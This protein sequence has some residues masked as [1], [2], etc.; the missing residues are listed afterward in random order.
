MSGLYFPPSYHT[1][2]FYVRYILPTQLPN[3]FISGK[4]FPPSYPTSFT[5]RIYFSPSYPTLLCLVYRIF[6]IGLVHAVLRY[7]NLSIEKQGI[8][9]VII[10]L[11]SYFLIQISNN[12]TAKITNNLEYINLFIALISTNRIDMKLQIFTILLLKK[13]ILSLI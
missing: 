1:Q 10:L 9:W 7:N 5:S 6:K 2:L 11:N 4:Y 12:L 3:S 8:F 13:L